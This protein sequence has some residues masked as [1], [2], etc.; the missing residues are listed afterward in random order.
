MTP[1]PTPPTASSGSADSL[2][3]DVNR[4]IEIYSR[5][6]LCLPREHRATALKL[7]ER[8]ED[9]QR[10]PPALSLFPLY[11][12]PPAPPAPAM[13]ADGVR[14]ITRAEL[15]QVAELTREDV[16]RILALAESVERCNDLSVRWK[17]WRE[18]GEEFREATRADTITALCLAALRGME[19]QGVT[20]DAKCWCGFTDDKHDSWCPMHPAHVQ[21]R[22]A[23]RAR[24]QPR[25]EREPPH[26][27]TCDCAT[28]EKS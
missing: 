4:L 11:A 7:I 15:K 10:T 8:I 24:T 2:L 9:A 21:R 20:D 23:E 18:A 1:T 27:P 12:F 26:C 16:E 6:I 22:A 13:Q 25:G 19:S 5:D 14:D 28:P 3:T 17:E